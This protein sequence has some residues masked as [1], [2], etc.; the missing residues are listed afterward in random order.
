MEASTL[1]RKVHMDC[2][3]CDKTHEVEVYWSTF[4]VTSRTDKLAKP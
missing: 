1:I 4:W 3:L 2:P